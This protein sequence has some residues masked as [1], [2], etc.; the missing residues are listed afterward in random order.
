MSQGQQKKF[1]RYFW[2]FF[3]IPLLLFTFLIL[4]VVLFGDLPSFEELENPKSNLASEIYSSDQVVLGKYY[5]QNRSNVHYEDL[6][7]N[8]INALKATEDIR[9]EE[10]SGVDI[11]GLFRVMIRTIILQQS[12]AGGGSTIT[13]Q[14]AKNLFPR[15]N[16]RTLHGKIITKIKEWI[17]SIKLE[18]NYTKNEILAMYLN[19]VEFGSNSFGIKAA[20][21]TFFDKSPKDL[22]V[23][24]AALLIG[25][26][27]APS[28]YSPLRNPK[29]ALTRR[30]V[31]LSQ[32]EKY[33]FIS[34]AD[35]DSLREIPIQLHYQSEDHTSGLAPHFREYLRL[36]L[37]KWCQE[38]T[39][40]DGSPYNLYSDGLRIYTTINS[41]MQRYAE[42]AVNQHL[43]ELQGKFFKHW[44]GRGAPWGSHTEVLTS[45]MRR[46]NR[47]IAL[48]KAG[49]TEKAIQKVFGTKIPMRVFTWNGD[50]DTLM[51]PMDSIRYYKYYL[52]TGFMSMEPQT[53]Y[54][55]AWVGGINYRYFKYDHVKEGK[56]QVGSTFKP[57]LYTLAM[58][59]GYSPCTRIP[60]VPVTITNEMG[61]P[62][63]PDNSE[64]DDDGKMMT[65]KEA[66]AKSVN[67]I[68]AYLV[69]QF[70]PQSVVDI[71]RKMGVTSELPPYPSICLGT[72]DISVYEMVG[73][74]S[75]F[76]NKG[77]W[78]EPIYITRIEDKNGNVL[79]ERLPRKVEALSEETNYLTLSLLQ[80]VV[81][82]GTGGSLRGRYKLYQPMAGKTGTTQNHSDGWYMGITP[83]LVSGCWVGCE[84]RSVHFRSLELGQ[85]AR[86]ALPIWAYYMQKVYADTTLD[87]SQGDF[88]RPSGGISVETDCSKYNQ[89]TNPFGNEF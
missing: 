48:K 7:P 39:K 49:V 25:L 89:T 63:T 20:A 57:F 13:Q 35:M 69:K 8:V 28:Y 77:V 53:G 19:T 27:K 30:N 38:H 66:L 32:L 51:S 67:R 46:S 72:A 2:I 23:N 40:A 68:S 15:E 44:E 14:L 79:E 4:G 16:F 6:S 3:L 47:Y 24:E 70:G 42:E 61:E 11:R 10:H 59:E 60:N 86:M 56:R 45:A 78:T 12:N 50:K 88:E 83:E 22:T 54:I 64:T 18:K 9:F 31:V 58:Q 41:K 34:S 36:E 62:W 17:T 71:A 73:A 33:S 74:Y 1:I 76:A 84:D 55:R 82:Y 52:Q 37:L 5:Y 87:V 75:T 85:G 80:G 65:L 81:Q 26:L 21:R 29:N 43:K